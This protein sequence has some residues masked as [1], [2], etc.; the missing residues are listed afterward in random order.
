MNSAPTG[1]GPQW[2]TSDGSPWWLRSTRY[3]EP[4]G[5]YLANCYLGIRGPFDNAANIKF[6]DNR[7]NFHSKSYYC[8]LKDQSV[9]PKPGSPEACKCENVALTGPY[10]AGG[11]IKCTG[12]LDVSRSTQKNSCPMGTKL[13]SPAS[14]RDWKTFLSSAQALRSPNFIIDITRPQ[15]GCGGCAKYP[16]NSRSPPQMTWRTA[17]GSPWWLRSSR[18]SQ[19]SSHYAAN[20]YMDLFKPPM[21]ENSVEFKATKC[22]FHSNA[23]YCQPVK[24]KKRLPPPPPAPPPPPPPAR[25]MKMPKKKPWY[26]KIKIAKWR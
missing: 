25:R 21:T 24:A 9:K 26:K 22:A 2:R 3:K 12:C 4:N 19:P 6:N 17:D 7:C 10:S 18:Y 23:Y 5:D 20:C 15:N 16:M 13:F 8:Q 11:L 1:Q 14:A